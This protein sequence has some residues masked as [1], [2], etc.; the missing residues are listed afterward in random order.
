MTASLRLLLPE[1]YER[2]WVYGQSQATL[3]SGY[4]GIT[5]M[6][7]EGKAAVK[8]AHFYPGNAIESRQP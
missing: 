4:R 5:V 2:A 1:A 3:D 6:I 8:I 7:E